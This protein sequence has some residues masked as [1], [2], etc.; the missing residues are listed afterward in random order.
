MNMDTFTMLVQALQIAVATSLVFLG[1]MHCH[2]G[3][4]DIRVRFKKVHVLT[5]SGLS[6]CLS[7]WVIPLTALLPPHLAA[8]QLTQT[9]AWGFQ[10]LQPSSRILMFALIITPLLTW[11]LPDPVQAENWKLWATALAI[12][13]PV[14]PYE[15][16]CIFPINDRVKEIGDELAKGSN[17]KQAKQELQDLFKKWQFRNFGRV[18]IPLVAGVVGWL[19]VVKE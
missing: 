16:Y 6:S 19:G 18:V 1:G 15:V 10:Y 11:R 5:R 7:L 2:F 17:E 14:A 3:L 4:S 12:L 13:V 9:V 8:K